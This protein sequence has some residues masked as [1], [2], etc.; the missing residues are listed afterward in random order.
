MGDSS[1]KGYVTLPQVLTILG[2]NTRLMADF[3]KCWKTSLADPS[4]RA[5]EQQFVWMLALSPDVAARVTH[6]LKA[7]G[8]KH[9]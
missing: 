4:C 7:F 1:G 6:Q 9:S 8:T 5:T 3:A 2:G